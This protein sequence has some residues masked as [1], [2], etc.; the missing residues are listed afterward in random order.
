MPMNISIIVL[1]MLD[2]SS[3]P[4][5]GGFWFLKNRPIKIKYFIFILR[6]VSTMSRRFYSSLFQKM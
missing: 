2:Q 4:S 1:D 3:K 5:L 6:I